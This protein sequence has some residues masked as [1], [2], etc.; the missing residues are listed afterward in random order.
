MRAAA[1]SMG[2][3]RIDI[4]ICSTASHHDF[5]YFRI[6]LF[7]GDLPDKSKCHLLVALIRKKISV[8]AAALENPYQSA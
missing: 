8:L 6:V 7:P 1:R 5:N 3:E 2:L 4:T